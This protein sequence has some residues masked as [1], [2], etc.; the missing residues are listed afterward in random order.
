MSAYWNPNELLVIFL[1]WNDYNQNDF[2][3]VWFE[4]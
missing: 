4:M 1:P 3:A 2:Y